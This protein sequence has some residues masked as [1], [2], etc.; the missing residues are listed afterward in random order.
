MRYFRGR[1]IPPQ[2]TAHALFAFRRVL[3][4]A[5]L[6][7]S[8]LEA[9]YIIL[10]NAMHSLPE[11]AVEKDD[12]GYRQVLAVLIWIPLRAALPSKLVTWHLVPAGFFQTFLFL[13]FCGKCPLTVLS[14]QSKG[15]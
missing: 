12:W 4:V 9:A 13:F 10:G 11:T 15:G 2:R 8:W 7:V 3:T 5:F 1:G 14:L 6:I